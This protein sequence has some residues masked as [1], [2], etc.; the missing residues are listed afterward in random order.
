[1]FQY[2]SATYDRDSNRSHRYLIDEG[3]GI[4]GTLYV[5]KEERQ[6]FRLNPHQVN[7]QTNKT[8]AKGP[9]GEP[10]YPKEPFLYPNP[11]FMQYYA[12]E[13]HLWASAM[14]PLLFAHPI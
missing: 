12:Q 13:H 1:M 4:T 9:Y 5:P 11:S 6:I 10:K 7:S 8:K 2:Q 14:L 3:Q